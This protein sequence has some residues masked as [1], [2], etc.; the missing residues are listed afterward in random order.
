MGTIEIKGLG[1]RWLCPDCGRVVDRAS[2]KVKD[3]GAK[4]Y[5]R[6]HSTHCRTPLV[7]C[8]VKLGAL[9][10]PES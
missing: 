9:H 2:T 5:R 7:R 8:T 1:L 6:Y 3:P 4:E 10:G